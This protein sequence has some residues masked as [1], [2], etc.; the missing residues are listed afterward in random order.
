[1]KHISPRLL[2]LGWTVFALFWAAHPAHDDNSS[3]KLT[4]SRPNILFIVTDDHRPDGARA[5]GNP[6]LM[7]PNLDRLIRRGASFTGVYN[8]GSDEPTVDNSSRAMLLTGQTCAHLPKSFYTAP[9]GKTSGEAENSAVTFPQYFR[10]Y[11]Y[12][13]YAVGKW[14]NSK[15]S[16]QASFAGGDNLFFE[17]MH[18]AKEG[19][20]LRPMLH[21]FD[22]KGAYRP[23]S[24]FKALGHSSAV[25]ASAA[26]SFLD[27][28]SPNKNNKPFLLYV[29]FTAPHDPFQPPASWAERYVPASLRLPENFRPQPL[30]DTGEMTVRDEQRLVRPLQP[31]AVQAEMAKYYASISDIDEQI[32]R[33]LQTLEING[34]TENTLVVWCSDNGLMLGQQGL[35]GK[36]NLYEPSVRVPLVMAGPGVRRNLRPDALCYLHDVFPTLC[37]LAKLPLP[38]RL[39]GQSF[40]SLLDGKEKQHRKQVL[41]AYRPPLQQAVRTADGWKLVQ[42]RVKNQ[43]TEQLFDLRQDPSELR[44]LSEQSGYQSQKQ[45]LLNL[46]DKKVS[47]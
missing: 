19:G 46:L 29:S 34:L 16:F 41:L 24:R 31:S 47:Q 17:E 4:E 28:Q 5:L 32:G 6:D 37:Q 12:Q 36:Q 25:F 22:A 20:H 43:T 8:A 15:T 39:D 30:F 45:K 10:K 3:P 38:T 11:G 26:I 2:V 27:K 18:A 42:Y 21:H 1:M 14:P 44:D 23:E 9:T 13:T 40:A 7:T 35:M 33:I